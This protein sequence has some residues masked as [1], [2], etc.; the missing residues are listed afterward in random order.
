MHKKKEINDY[1]N[2]NTN[3]ENIVILNQIARLF[4]LEKT[5]CSFFK[6]DFNDIVKHRKFLE[7]DVI[8]VQKILQKPCFVGCLL[9]RNEH[10]MYYIK[11]IVRFV[12]KQKKKELTKATTAWVNHNIGERQKYEEV[13]FATISQY[14]EAKKTYWNF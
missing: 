5:F 8:L 3:I 12:F 4:Y 1:F 9:E 13:L 14:F 2:I 6:S 11:S 10:K 7:L